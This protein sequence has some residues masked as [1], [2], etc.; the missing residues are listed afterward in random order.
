LTGVLSVTA[1]FRQQSIPQ[2]GKV[3]LSAVFTEFQQEYGKLSDGELLQLA[4]DSS[5]LVDEAKAALDCEMR[6]RGLTHD[7]LGKHQ[8]LLKQSELRETRKRA[9]KL[10]RKTASWVD[11]VV[12]LFWSAFGFALI[13]I[14][15]LAVPPRYRFSPDWQ[16]AAGYAMFA[17]AFLIA[18]SFGRWLKKVT[19]WI[20]L[21][22]SS[23]THAC[24]VHAWIVRTGSLDG[25]R[26]PG[27]V[28][29]LLGPVL[30]LVVYG[31]GYFLRRKLHG[32]ES[33]IERG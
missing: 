14:A 11:G 32:G 26:G 3:S 4:S 5:S 15:Y 7:D 13:W 16:E 31:S 21:L 33:G 2:G 1:C 22:I 27:N 28:A 9:R 6:N 18:A 30:F 24:I 19:F 12:T 17:A 10:R 8:N 25:R 20:S 23:V 29:V